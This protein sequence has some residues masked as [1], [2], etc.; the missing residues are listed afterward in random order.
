VPVK[1]A[2][3]IGWSL[4]PFL[5]RDLLAKIGGI[6]Y[7]TRP[8]IRSFLNRRISGLRK[9]KI[10]DELG[11][12]ELLPRECREFRLQ[13]AGDLQLRVCHPDHR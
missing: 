2:R 13:G 7:G 9:L 10:G 12:G 6:P 11:L 5:L 8:Q 1:I 3:K 4:S